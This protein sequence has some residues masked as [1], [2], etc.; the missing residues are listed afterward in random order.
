MIPHEHRLNL[1]KKQDFFNKSKRY[2]TDHFII[3]YCFIIQDQKSKLVV[4]V[5]KKNAKKRVIRSKIKRQIYAVALPLL[6]ENPG[7]E[8]V[9]VVKSDCLKITFEELTIQIKSIFKNLVKNY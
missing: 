4:V 7:L 2:F 3:F 1:R 6:K 5:P 8:L 9:M